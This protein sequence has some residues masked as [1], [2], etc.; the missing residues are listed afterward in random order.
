MEFLVT[1]TTRVP[2][3]TPEMDVEEIRSREAANS[4]KLAIEGHMLRLWRPPLGP[5]EWRSIGLFAA[6]DA[7]ELEA[8]LA[9]MPLRIWRTDEVTPL[10]VHPN[11][12]PVRRSSRAPEFLVHFHTVVPAGTPDQA[13]KDRFAQEAERAH[14]LAGEGHLQRLWALPAEPGE[15]RSVS[16]WQARDAADMQAVLKSLPLDRWMDVETTPLTQHP[17]DPALVTEA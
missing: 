6:D 4:R 12:P 9:G 16:L 17:N 10:G 3:G 2:D 13:V 7:D 5:E 14:E 1:M 11:D 8:I 15:W